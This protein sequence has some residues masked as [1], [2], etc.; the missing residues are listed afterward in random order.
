MADM[1]CLALSS[2]TGMPG[3][4]SLGPHRGTSWARFSDEH[5]SG[6][7]SAWM[8]D[9]EVCRAEGEGEGSSHEVLPSVVPGF[10]A[11][12]SSS[13]LGGPKQLMSRLKLLNRFFLPLFPVLIEPAC[14]SE[15]LRWM[16]KPGAAVDKLL[17]EAV[18]VEEGAH[19]QAG[20]SSC[21]IGNSSWSTTATPA[22]ASISV[23][24]HICPTNLNSPLMRFSLEM[25]ELEII[26]GL[27]SDGSDRNLYNVQHT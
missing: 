7:V 19:S 4:L 5:D 10:K 22:L 24:R 11:Q 17:E 2:P 8:L 18:G 16:G 23:S 25:V 21:S 3:S 12:L 14:T 9:M 1:L 20:A 26:L 27:G 6:A 15:L 13:T